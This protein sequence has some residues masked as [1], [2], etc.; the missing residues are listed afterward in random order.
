MARAKVQSS[1]DLPFQI[2]VCGTNNSGK[3]KLCN[4]L[5]GGSSTGNVHTSSIDMY[6][7]LIEDGAKLRLLDFA[8]SYEG[9]A[10]YIR[11]H[12]VEQSQ[13]C[14]VCVDRQN[15]HSFEV[16]KKAVEEIREFDPGIPI[17]IALTKEDQNLGL[18]DYEILVKD[19]EL[20]ALEEKYGLEGSI[21]TSGINNK[22]GTVEL[23][24]TLLKL[25]EEI[26]VKE[27]K[28]VPDIESIEEYFPETESLDEVKKRM[29]NLSVLVSNARIEL[30]ADAALESKKSAADDL[31]AKKSMD[32]VSEFSKKLTEITKIPDQMRGASDTEKR[33]AMLKAYEGALKEFAREVKS[34]VFTIHPPKNVKHV[35]IRIVRAVLLRKLYTDDEK[36]ELQRVKH[37]TDFKNRLQKEEGRY[38]E[39]DSSKEQQ[40]EKKDNSALDSNTP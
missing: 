18:H 39:K 32:V 28:E 22:E 13:I 26:I 34:D 8:G 7:T 12:Y 33:D 2:M 27:E 40:A 15:S 24:S 21:K 23:R 4:A 5:R 11:K 17:V 29:H 31:A 37:Q 1:N 38:K 10:P 30:A 3:T 20:R 9:V 16:A 6:D 14:V 35:L 19:R 25:R 36:E